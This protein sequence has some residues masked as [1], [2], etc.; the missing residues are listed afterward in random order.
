MLALAEPMQWA[1]G[2][3][4]QS[5]ELAGPGGRERHKRLADP[6]KA[7]GQPAVSRWDQI[8]DYDFK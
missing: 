2:T 5:A 1:E 6:G 7:L 8:K 4:A 3:G